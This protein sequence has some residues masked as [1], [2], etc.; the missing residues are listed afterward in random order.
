MKELMS[1]HTPQPPHSALRR[2]SFCRFALWCSK[3]PRQVD[4]QVT[5]CDPSNLKYSTQQRVVVQFTRGR[6]SVMK[7]RSDSEFPILKSWCRLCSPY[8]QHRPLLSIQTG[9]TGD[10]GVL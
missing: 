9:P 3:L 7:G 5:G 4:K 2:T 8:K 1:K 10:V 6:A